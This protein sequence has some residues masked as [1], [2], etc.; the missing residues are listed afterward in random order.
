MPSLKELR[1]NGNK[2]GGA[3]AAALADAL[4]RRKCAIES[5]G[6]GGNLWATTA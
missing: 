4:G 3:G 2:I 6:L 1:L 5:L